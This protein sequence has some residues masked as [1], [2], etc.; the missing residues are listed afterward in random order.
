MSAFV[1]DKF[2][3]INAES[4][5]ESI[6]N[7]SYYI[8]LGLSNP[9][10]TTVISGEGPTENDGFG[11]LI[12]WDT[13]TANNPVDNLQY[14]SHYRDTCLFGKKIIPENA[15]RVVKKYEWIQNS[16]YDVY[17]HDYGPNNVSL[18]SQSERLY[19]SIYYVITSEYKVYIC[20]ENGS[21]GT[22]TVSRSQIEPNH[23]DIEPVLY[24]DGYKWKYLFRVSPADV[25]KFD[26]TEYIILP[27]DW[28]TTT[29]SE[30]QSIREGGDSFNNNNQ[31]KT[32][33]IE[34]G[35]SGYGD[36]FTANI[37]GDGVGGTVFVTTSS[38]VIDNVIVTNGGYGYTYGTIELSG[39]S[40]AKLVPIIPP[41]RGHGYDIYDELGA[42]KI[43]LYARFDDSTKN[44][45]VDTK[46]S[47]VGILKN[48]E[49]FSSLSRTNQNFTE[50]TFSA[51]YSIALQES[52]SVEIGNLVT[53]DQG[54]GIVAEGY[55]AS[56]DKETKI[57]KY[58][59]DRSLSFANKNDQ[60]DSTYVNKNIIPFVSTE[61]V[62]VNANNIGNSVNVEI[63]TSI[64]NTNQL[65]TDSGKVVDLGVTFTNGLS[66]PQINKKTG[67]IIYI[68]NRPI[69]ERNSRQKEDI[70]IILEF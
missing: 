4:F 7:N 35:G 3:I 30:I 41:S 65:T 5:I 29:D 25:I 32:V 2:R 40:G 60:T 48:P 58:Y 53:Q 33:Y 18:A 9:D 26:S 22:G 67:D 24:N 34:N 19:S 36:S 27:N 64:N 42:D 23:T 50:N 6:S 56:F 10:N 55:I 21:S 44:F 38:G 70:K 46:F 54:N 45:P 43:L 51:L 28:M 13:S 8:F 15:R 14:L 1:T 49:T 66:N 39:G 57:L 62:L 31:I 11:R 20:I 61:S 12:N 16:P 59:Q 47:Q 17:R 52:V 68:D 69:V 37:L 63:D